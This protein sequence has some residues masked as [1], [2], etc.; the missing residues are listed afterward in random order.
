MIVP[1]F[2]IVSGS[3]C[4]QLAGK[5]TIFFLLFILRFFLQVCKRMGRITKKFFSFGTFVDK[6]TKNAIMFGILTASYL[7]AA[8]LC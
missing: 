7:T 8:L 3:L 2:F 4:F 1:P 6:P 5:D